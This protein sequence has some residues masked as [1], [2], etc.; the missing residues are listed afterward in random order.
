MLER[1]PIRFGDCRPVIPEHG[2]VDAVEFFKQLNADRTFVQENLQ[3]QHDKLAKQF[4]KKRPTHVYE[5]G[6]KV[7]YKGHTKDT[8]CKLYRV[9]TGPGEILARIGRNHY[10][11]ATDKGEINLDTMRLKLYIPPHTA[12]GDGEHAAPLHHYTDQ[13]FL[14]ETDKYRVEKI[15]DH[16]LKQAT[17][18]EKTKWLV[19]YK[20]Y[21]DPE[22][23]PASS[24]MHDI[25]EDWLAYN[26]NYRIDVGIEDVRIIYTPQSNPIEDLL[27]VEVIG[28]V[29]RSG[30]YRILLQENRERGNL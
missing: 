21:P 9:W 6:D 7:W 4:L 25:D 30:R 15:L 17:S 28:S 8:N 22:W 3:A 2:S 23:Q 18:R 19:E 11:V 24:L 16:K 10:T 5:P 20:G 27:E 26:A 14:V 13:E 12:P 29:T 1:N